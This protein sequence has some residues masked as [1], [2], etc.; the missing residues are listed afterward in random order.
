MD[1]IKISILGLASV[2]L[3]VLL[4]G[5]KP[6]YSFY[7]SFTAGIIMLL[8]AASKVTYLIE[9][10]QKIQNA[11][12]IDAA[13]MGILFKMIGITY[14]GQFTANICKDAGNSAIAAQIEL[15][16]KLSIMVIS[17]PVL[18]GLLDTI[19]EFLK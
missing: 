7:I 13:S 15:F 11:I 4:N 3:G 16:S 10:V 2:I 12:P 5:I 19:Q 18:L 14:I 9:S 8:L 6:E 17:M 1:I